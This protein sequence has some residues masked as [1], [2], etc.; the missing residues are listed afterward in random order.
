MSP[1]HVLEQ[2][3]PLTTALPRL[4][5]VMPSASPSVGVEKLNPGVHM[6]DA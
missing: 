4:L 1:E 2:V 3:E 6:P 5:F